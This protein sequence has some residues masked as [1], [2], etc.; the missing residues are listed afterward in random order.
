MEYFIYCDESVS[1]GRYYSDFYGGALVRSKDFDT[2]KSILD[3]KK[4]ELN[5]FNEI[6]W[7]KV[8]EAYLDKYKQMMD[9]FFDLIRQDKVKIRI[10]FR[11]NAKVATN[12]SREQID[13]GF[14]LLY[15]QFVKH[16]FGLKYHR[17]SFTNGDTYIRLYFDRLPNTNAQNETFKSHIYDLQNLRDFQTAKIKIRMEDIVEIDSKEHSILQC[18]DIILGAMAFRLNDMHLE[19]PNG[20]RCRGKKT[21]AKEKLYRHILSLIRTLERPNFNIGD[22][23]GGKS[24]ARWEERYRHW[25]FIPREFTEDSSKYKH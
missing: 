13:N 14:H 18:V 11:Q 10:M 2:V 16:A 8:T 20:A 22:S 25:K 19:K 6:K 17:E 9:T 15:Y 21:I 1:K 4:A 12:L 7:T 23:T 5:L 3:N 24:I